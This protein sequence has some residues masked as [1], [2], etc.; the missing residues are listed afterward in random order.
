MTRGKAPKRPFDLVACERAMAGEAI[1]LTIQEKRYVID[2]MTRQ[3]SSALEVAEHIGMTRRSVERIRATTTGDAP[4]EA[5][6]SVAWAGGK[7]DELAVWAKQEAAMFA[8]A[9]RDVSPADN[10]IRLAFLSR[11]EL[12]ALT[13]ALAAMV[14]VDRTA[15]ELTAWTDELEAVA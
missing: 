8:F 12:Q 7:R 6:E 11:V 3:G 14:P 9:V 4:A 10:W 15:A 13:V 5:V 2:V 1:A